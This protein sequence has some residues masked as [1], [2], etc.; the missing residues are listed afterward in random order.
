MLQG[1]EASTMPTDLPVPDAALAALLATV[2]LAGI[3]RGLSGF[4]TGMIVA[5]VAGAL[6]GPQVAIVIIVIMDSLPVLP[7]TLP[8]LRQAR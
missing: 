8:A 5:P 7:V 1:R 3:A 4:G 6:Y 2:L